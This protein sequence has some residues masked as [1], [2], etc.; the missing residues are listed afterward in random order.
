MNCWLYS[1]LLQVCFMIFL[2]KQASCN[3]PVHN[4]SLLLSP[5]PPLPNS[6]TASLNILRARPPVP[7]V[8]P[9]PNTDT[10]LIVVWYYRNMVARN[11][12]ACIVESL[13]ELYATALYDHGDGPVRADTYGQEQ[14]GVS[15]DVTRYGASGTPPLYYSTVVR[16][17][18]GMAQ[19]LRTL[20]QV[21][22]ISLQ[23]YER[24]LEV[25]HATL[26]PANTPSS[27]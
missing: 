23:V 13:A 7:F 22:G 11:V 17:F 3:L 2:L 18:L 8:W 20:D 21:C 4:I 15:L 1:L 26:K 19:I 6:S 27:T 14:H 9:I 12:F 24:G 10:E 5:A 25:A 16:T